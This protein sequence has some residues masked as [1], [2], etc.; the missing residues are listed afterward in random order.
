MGKEAVMFI[1]ME[2]VGAGQQMLLSDT[3]DVVLAMVVCLTGVVL[4]AVQ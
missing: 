3:A 2:S 1:F 4:M